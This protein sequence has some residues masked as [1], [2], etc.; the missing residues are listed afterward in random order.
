MLICKCMLHEKIQMMFCSNNWNPATQRSNIPIG[1]LPVCVLGRLPTTLVRF[2]PYTNSSLVQLTGT[3][4]VSCEGVA[5]GMCR[6]LAYTIGGNPCVDIG[7]ADIWHKVSCQC[8]TS[9]DPRV[10]AIWVAGSVS[11]CLNLNQLVLETSNMLCY[12]T[13]HAIVIYCF[14]MQML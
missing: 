3:A 10:T 11:L 7:W 1:G 4:P 12:H 5:R 9:A 8:H 6:H 14:V 2:R 13:S